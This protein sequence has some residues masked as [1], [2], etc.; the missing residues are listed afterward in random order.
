VGKSVVGAALPGPGGTPQPGG[1]ARASGGVAGSEA[2]GRVIFT[3]GATEAN[4]L[5]LFGLAGEPGGTIVSNLGEHPCVVEPLKTLA[6]EGHLINWLPLNA[7]GQVVRLAIDARLAAIALANH[8]TGAINAIRSIARDL[9]DPT[10]M[11]P[12]RSARCT[13]AFVSLGAISMS[14]SAHKFGGPKGCGALLLKEGVKLQP[15][16]YGGFQQQGRRPG[17]ESARAPR[18]EWLRH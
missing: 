15:R 13:S 10:P 4:N 2:G 14:V 3:S 7:E 12:R 6:K 1:I 17:T 5:A 9:A 8:E 16:S 11:R 18:P